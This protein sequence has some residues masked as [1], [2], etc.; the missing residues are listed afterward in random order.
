MIKEI[1]IEAFAF[2]AYAL[3]FGYFM[4][5]AIMAFKKEEYFYFGTAL[6]LATCW[7]VH[8]VRVAWFH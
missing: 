2:V 6:A 5:D 3:L 1:F 7:F 4:R 8:I